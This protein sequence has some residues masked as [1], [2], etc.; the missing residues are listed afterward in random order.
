MSKNRKNTGTN[1][2]LG[3]VIFILLAIVALGVCYAAI[4]KFKDWTDEKIFKK[5]Q[6]K[7][8][9]AEALESA[10]FNNYTITY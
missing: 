2:F 5:E 4:P 7:E 10:N 9:D 6:T 8:E 1:I 3:I